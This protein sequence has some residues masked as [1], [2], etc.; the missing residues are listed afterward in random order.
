[1]QSVNEIWHV[2]VILQK[3]KIYQK[4]LQKI[5]CLQRIKHNLYWKM[6]FLKEATHISYALAELSKFVKISTRPPQ[7]PFYR[8]FLEN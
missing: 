4:I 3:K 5:L 1:M 7:I 2:Y 6:K 8:E